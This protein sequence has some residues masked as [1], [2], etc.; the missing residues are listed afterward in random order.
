VL[1]LAAERN[2]RKRDFAE[3]ADGHARVI[4]PLA[5]ELATT[6]SASRGPSPL[7]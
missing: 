1:E 5:H 3:Q 2:F 6:M 7:M 4:A